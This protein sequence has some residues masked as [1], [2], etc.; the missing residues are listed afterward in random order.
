MASPKTFLFLD[1]TKERHDHFYR[2]CSN[3]DVITFHAWGVRRA[4]HLLRD[5]PFG[6]V[7]DCVWLDHD[8]EDTGLET[9][10]VVAEHIA[11]HL[12]MSMRPRNVVIHSWNA[13]GAIAMESILL[14][15]GYTSVKRV[16]FSFKE[17][18]ETL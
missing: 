15:N 11:L 13:D 10:Y 6:S 7:F 17:P 18:D 1:D 9:G 8:L 4:I 12:P 16:P 14:I 2:L 3:L 5:P